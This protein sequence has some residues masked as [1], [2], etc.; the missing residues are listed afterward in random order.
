MR[1]VAPGRRRRADPS[2]SLW[3][4]CG[5]G[6]R[7]LFAIVCRSI[8]W[9]GGRFASKFESSRWTHSWSRSGTSTR[10]G[11]G[12]KRAIP[13]SSEPRACYGTA[14][15]RRRLRLQS[16]RRTW[17]PPSCETGA[18]ST[19]SCGRRAVGLPRLNHLIRPQ[20]FRI[21]PKSKDGPLIS[22]TDT[23]TSKCTGRLIPKREPWRGPGCSLR[24]AIGNWPSRSQS[25]ITR[26]YGA[27]W[28]T[29]D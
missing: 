8:C 11:A 6:V 13:R 12:R 27:P 22:T 21:M 18:T 28:T 25:I 20:W 16:G 29:G 2:L 4:S 14:S 3:R 10:S 23:K 19:V 24:S 17:R 1:G 9:I 7:D 26:S 5:Q 15:Q